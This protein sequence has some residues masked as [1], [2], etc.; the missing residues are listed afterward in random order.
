MGKDLVKNNGSRK[1]GTIIKIIITLIVIFA[2]ANVVF[3]MKY[4]YNY[5][6]DITNF[7]DVVAV[8]I[9]SNSPKTVLHDSDDD[10]TTFIAG[11]FFDL[12]KYMTKA[13]YKQ[14]DQMGSCWTYKNDSEEKITIWRSEQCYYFYIYG[15]SEH[16][17]EEFV[18]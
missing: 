15:I 2:I 18:Q 6:L 11:R 5:K 12:D 16:S 10:Y 4:L 3:I 1:V 8:N 13:G 9:D 14:C 17:I 7:P